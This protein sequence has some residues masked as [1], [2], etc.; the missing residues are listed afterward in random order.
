[1]PLRLIVVYLSVY[2][3]SSIQPSV[4]SSVPL[5]YLSVRPSI[6]S[7][8]HLGFPSG[9]FT[10]GFPTNTL[11][12]LLFVMACHMPDPSRPPCTILWRIYLNY[13]APACAVF[14]RIMPLPFPCIQVHFWGDVGHDYFAAN[15]RVLPT[16]ASEFDGRQLNYFSFPH[17]VESIAGH[18]VANVSHVALCQAVR[19]K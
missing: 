13:E 19:S 14:S 16:C 5:I 4:C 1:M 7:Y 15:S 12:I 10:S 6:L 9:L 11:C 8:I 17:F 18:C 3:Y 2:I